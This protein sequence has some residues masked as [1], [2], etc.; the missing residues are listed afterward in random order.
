M[1]LIKPKQISGEI[2]TLLDEADE[3]VIIVS[4]YIQTKKWTKLKKTINDIKKRNI[5]IEVYYRE[6]EYETEKEIERLELK[7]FPIEKLHCKLYM[8][9][10]EAITSSMNLY[11]YSDENSLDI[12]HITETK[13]EFEELQEFYERY[14]VN[15]SDKILSIDEVIETIEEYVSENTGNNSYGKLKN[16]EIVFQYMRNRYHFYFLENKFVLIGILSGYEYD[17]AKLDFQLF[18][19][20]HLD[21]ILNEGGNGNYS[22]LRV[23][24]SLKSKSFNSFYSSDIELVSKSIIMFLNKVQEIKRGF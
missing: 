1:K 23:D 8:N 14:I 9:E 4:P 6:G 15:S 16:D 21:F 10:K 13:K 24:L 22:N 18:Y 20:Q 2:M 19:N 12:A 7:G 5:P 3:K 11:Q 17:R